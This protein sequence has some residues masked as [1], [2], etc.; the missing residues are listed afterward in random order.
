MD[1]V[2]QFVGSFTRRWSCVLYGPT[3]VLC[4][5]WA[6]AGP[7]SCMG[8]RWSCVLYGP[9]LVLCPVW[10]YAGLRGPAEIIF[11][12]RATYATTTLYC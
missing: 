5:V 8:L 4:P 1:Q 10:A 12:A 9:T 11:M 3:L 7:V 6:Y 2:P